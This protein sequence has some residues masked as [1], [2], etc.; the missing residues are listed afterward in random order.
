[1]NWL[2]IVIL[3]ALCVFTYLGLKRG[4][5]QAVI[6]LIGLVCAIYLAGSMHESLA[7]SLGFIDN[8][9]DAKII[10][11]GIILG[12]VFL[13]VCVIAIA[14]KKFISVMFLGWIDKQG[15]AVLGFI[16]GWLICSMVVAVLA[17]NAALPSELPDGIPESEVKQRVI[18]NLDGA[19]E[20]TYNAINGS[21]FATFQI[22]TF[23]VVLGLL[24]GDFDA[25]KDYFGD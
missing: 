24:P 14:M 15:G 2:D 25:V 1:M 11:F 19:R 17:R 6:P 8:D 23:P 12:G 16:V 3:V 13:V 22:D 9:S 20:K 5:I 10:A 18:D 7:K 4:F 21:T